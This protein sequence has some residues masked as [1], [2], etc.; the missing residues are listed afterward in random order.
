[1][2]QAV[3]LYLGIDGGG[4]GCRAAI[5]RDG[6]V[7][8]GAAGPANLTSDFEGGMANLRSAITAAAQ[9]AGLG[10]AELEQAIGHAGLAGV[11]T[12]DMARKVAGQLP[13]RCCVTE[14]RNIAI[15][16]ALGAEGDGAVLAIGTGS[17]VGLRRGGTIRAVGGWGLQLSDQASGGWL[18]RAA[19]AATLEAVNS[20]DEQ[21]VDAVASEHAKCERCWHYRPEVG[22]IAEETSAAIVQQLTGG[23]VDKAAIA[24]AVKSVRG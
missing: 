14:D 10:A 17:F 3:S 4:T 19:L 8:Q 1:M 9:S 12:D 22:S 21:R 23:K 16:G 5:W 7:G 2:K 11:Q 18:G 15:A 13:G 20:E 6:V 24:A